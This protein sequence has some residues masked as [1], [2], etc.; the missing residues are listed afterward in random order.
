MFQRFWYKVRCRQRKVKKKTFDHFDSSVLAGI[1]ATFISHYF[2]KIKFGFAFAQVDQ[3]EKFFGM[4][5]NVLLTFLINWNEMLLNAAQR[6][7]MLFFARAKEE[8]ILVPNCDES[9]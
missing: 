7:S 3:F 2:L 4:K 1:L 5:Q 8:F 6:C 9:D